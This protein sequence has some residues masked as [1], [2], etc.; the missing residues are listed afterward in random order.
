MRRYFLED[1]QTGCGAYP[2]FCSTANGGTSKEVKRPECEGDHSFP[3]PSSHPSVLIARTGAV[4][5]L[6]LVLLCI[7]YILRRNCLLKQIIEGNI[8][9]GMNWQGEEEEDVSCYWMTLRK[10]GC[11]KLKEE[12]LDRTVCRTRICGR[13]LRLRNEWI[14][15]TFHFVFTCR[16]I[17]MQLSKDMKSCRLLVS[18]LRHK[19]KY[20]IYLAGP[21]IRSHSIPVRLQSSACIRM[22]VHLCC[23]VEAPKWFLV[24]WKLGGNIRKWCF[25][26]FILL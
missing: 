18:V 19:G 5:C 25:T 20:S 10:P 12:A 21:I 3:S 23:N 8:G 1:V 26:G 14:V 16:L 11:F 24:W 17:K 9:G 22:L 2:A 15:V 6:L 4:V 13:D 7:G